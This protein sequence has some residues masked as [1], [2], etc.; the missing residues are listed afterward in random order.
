MKLWL[1]KNKIKEILN[2]KNRLYKC[3]NCGKYTKEKIFIRAL[4]CFKNEKQHFCCEKCKELYID[5][6]LPP[7]A[8]RN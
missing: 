5:S 3:E 1:F 7:Q 6:L 2:I 8:R 4:G